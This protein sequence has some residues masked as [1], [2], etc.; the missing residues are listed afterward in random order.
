MTDASPSQ[1]TSTTT[2]VMGCKLPHGYI[3]E[4][5][6]RSF[7]LNGNNSA[8][9]VGGYGLTEGV[10]KDFAEAWLTKNADL[11][12]VKNGLVFIQSSMKEARAEA[13]DRRTLKTGLEPVDP[14]AKTPDGAP[15][16]KAAELALRKQRAENPDRNRQIVE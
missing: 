3:L 9:I 4:L 5:G 11:A 7:R 16:D 13:A 2:V 6:T 14:M 15:L 8:R 1:K 12:P 10:P